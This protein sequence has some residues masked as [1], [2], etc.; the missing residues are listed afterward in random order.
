MLS[1]GI[2]RHL[3]N[4]SLP[5]PD[6]VDQL[7][8]LLGQLLVGRGMT[9]EIPLGPSLLRLAFFCSEGRSFLSLVDEV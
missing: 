4:T 2:R 9:V 5:V 7:A 6:D 8:V 1:T 3:S